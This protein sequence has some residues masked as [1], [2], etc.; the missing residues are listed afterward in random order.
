MVDIESVNIVGNE[1]EILVR[2]TNLA[3]HKLP[4][5]YPSRRMWINLEIKDALG[6]VVFDSGT[7]DSRGHL[8][9]DA[10]HLRAGCTDLEPTLP[11][12]E[13]YESHRNIIDSP[14]Q[15]AI[16]ESVLGDTNGNLTYVLLRGDS[17]L[18][19]NRIPPKGFARSAVPTDGVTA[20]RGAAV[21]DADFN[22]ET[23]GR[24]NG[25]DL[26][27]YRVNVSG[28]TAPYEISVR[29]LYQSVRPTFVS[30]LHQDSA[31]RVVRYK[32]MYEQIPPSVELLAESADTVF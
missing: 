20:I 14:D 29:L 6:E 1:R 10:N 32:D 31:P 19:D 22:A 17:Y 13:C 28:Y 26:V 21:N 9:V 24:G 8:T 16:Y 15:I 25:E 5:A 23:L 30:G 12:G 11:A 7:P 4:S 27:R 18:K 3:G 2:V